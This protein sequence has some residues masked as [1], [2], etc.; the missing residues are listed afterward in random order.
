MPVWRR[1]ESVR[2]GPR[3]PISGAI[4]G[5]I[6]LGATLALASGFQV[7]SVQAHAA[8]ATL[9]VSG[10]LELGLTDRVEEAVDNGIPIELTIDIR[11]YRRRALIWDQRLAQWRLRREL[12]YHALSGQYLV[13]G[14]SDAPLERENFDSLNDALTEMGTLPEV[15]LALDQPLESDA[16]YRVDL[17]V[18]LD[19]EALPSLLRPVAYTSRAWDLNSGWTTWKLQR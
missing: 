1:L 10:L 19:I 4:T 7:S 2:G 11:L 15:M 18:A 13:G 6:F 16:D 14:A 9:Y 3:W 17:R 5:V 8:G 12:R